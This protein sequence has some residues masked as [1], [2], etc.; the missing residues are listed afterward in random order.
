MPVFTGCLSTRHFET[1]QFR[2]YE[3]RM[4][5]QVKVLMVEDVATDAEF[6]LRE[7]RSNGYECINRRVE[8][9]KELR[10]ELAEFKPDVILSDFS[11]SGSLDGKSVLA[12]SRELAPEIPFIF[13]SGT[14]GEEKAIDSL[15]SGT[16]SYVLKT[17]MRRLA[18]AVQQ[19]LEAIEFKK[20]H[21]KAE[22][23]IEKQRAFFRKVIDLDRNLI[24][25]KDRSGRFVLA[26]QSLASIYGTTP[27]QILGKTDQ[28]FN[29]NTDEV[30]LFHHDDLQVMDTLQEQIIPEEKVTDVNGKVHW[31]QTVKCPIISSDGSADM[32]L[33]VSTDI[34]ERKQMEDELRQNIKRFETISQA[35][36]D[37][38]WDWNLDTDHLWWNESFKILFGY[39]DDEIEPHINFWINRVHID[40][41]ELVKN[42][43]YQVI[44][45]NGRYWN[46][47]YR[48]QRRDGTYAYVYDRGF[49]MRDDSGKGTHMI[50][51]MI[52]MTERH[53]QQVKIDSLNWIREVLIGINHAIVRIH[54]R[55]ALC[56]EACR[57]A[58]DHGNFEFAWIG[59]ANQD[60]GRILPIANC[61][62]DQ[63]YLETVQF[64]LN[65]KIPEG[66]NLVSKAWRQ[67]QVKVCENISITKDINV[68][69]RRE[70]SRRGF[71]SL[72][73][74]PL[75]I[76]GE[77]VGTFAL[78]SYEIGA[79]NEDELKL[80]KDMAADISFALEYIEKERKLNYL[81]YYDVLTGLP[82]HALFSDRVTQALYNIEDNKIFGLLLLDI[83]RFTN[84][85]DVFGRHA[86]DQILKKIATSLRQILPET[87]HLAHI[88]ADRFALLV[89]GIVTA[90]DIARF[91]EEKLIPGLMGP[92]AVEDKQV[93]ISIR[94]G[95]A[96]APT[97]GDD[98][99]TLLKNSE[100]ALKSAKRTDNKYLFY[101]RDMNAL[102]A[103]K[104]TLENR[105]REALEK[106]EFVVFYQPKISLANER[107]CGLEALVR[108]NSPD[109]GMVSPDKFIPLLE[110]TGMILDVGIWVL[111]KAKLDYHHWLDKGLP[112]PPI[113]VNVSPVQLRQYDF[114]TQI[115]EV[116]KH[117]SSNGNSLEFEITESL[118]M[119]N[120]EENI[121][122][123]K[124]FRED[125]MGISID[126]FGTG[127]SSL[128]YMSK[129]PV[130]ALKIDR[131]FISNMLSSPNDTSIVTAIITLA[132][133]L[134]LK[135]IAEGVETLEQANLLKLLRCDQY[136]GYLYSEP[137][138]PSDIESI[139][140]RH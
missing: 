31:L 58:V 24:F 27:E 2:T 26:N 65:V 100:A 51:A 140:I 104:L 85:N 81:A 101:A 57:V 10:R 90:A 4:N 139:L 66:Q 53:E 98:A 77:A 18:S 16:T 59:M 129:L 40:D 56:Q 60:S 5:R 130:T 138:S 113:S 96:V 97:D 115:N 78:Y 132:H 39:Q 102:I 136:Q 126:D 47:E 49:V 75:S 20:I 32:V 74:L 135:V 123:L 91:L 118:M 70:L 45:G 23:D 25:A 116:L 109:D 3:D 21:K 106:D 83:E 7:M 92:H 1:P 128:S 79:F 28:D 125:G 69:Y 33:G 112:A 52:D 124:V 99:E 50:G 86:G 19:A 121:Q 68:R 120:L 117:Y 131:T 41:R 114:V 107:I 67:N 93:K 55:E 43:I 54:D 63:G 134:N 110:E 61:G 119:E 48:F 105:L 87:D 64:C 88:G 13:V 8:N 44:Q 42:S 12:I 71:Q 133:S 108:W 35:T 84:I 73:V 94:V 34:T 15:D 11:M 22:R 80:L 122:K 38:V 76:E 30:D 95:I 103:E 62:T 37:A 9:E 137:V 36:N 72:A 29:P 89:T 127:Y 46:D 6:E 111:N 82:N 17:N 14:T